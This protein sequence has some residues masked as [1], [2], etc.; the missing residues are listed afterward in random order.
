MKQSYMFSAL[1]SPTYDEIY[2]KFAASNLNVGNILNVIILDSSPTH[3]STPLL[4]KILVLSK[5][6]TYI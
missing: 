6:V 4:G 1:N 3:N 2:V 5:Y